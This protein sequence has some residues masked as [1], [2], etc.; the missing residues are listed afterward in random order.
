[1][2]S[3]PL[4]SVYIPTHNRASLLTRA[5]DSVLAQSYPNI[6]ILVCSDGS[7][8]GTDELM[9]NLCLA[10][11]NIY[12]FKNESPEGACAARNKCIKNARGEF[13][14]GLDDDD[15]FHPQRIELMF[16][17]F[18]S[19]Y[20]FV[21]A[22]QI[23][24]D[25]SENNY[26]FETIDIEH[27]PYKLV[28]LNELLTYN[29]IGNQVFTLTE[30]FR[31]IDCF[32]VNQLAWQ[33]YDTW[34]R[35]MANYGPAKQ[36]KADAYYVDIDDSRPRISISSKRYLGC[37]QFYDKHWQL[38][39]ASQHKNAHVRM[40]IFAGQYPSVLT[41][42]SWFNMDNWKFWL[43]AMLIKFNLMSE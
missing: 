5:I 36:I 15:V 9:S 19:K 23:E 25:L 20:A 40:A 22:G 6:E 28:T 10:H 34:V 18:D 13:C 35:L 16:K 1:M 11:E 21:S 41:L 17:H 42:I 2:A 31:A 33:D 30:R 37:K 43:K 8:D 4:I 12:Y 26:D 32:D 27:S 39:S 3:Y 14:T 7:T 24:V 29:V 38:M